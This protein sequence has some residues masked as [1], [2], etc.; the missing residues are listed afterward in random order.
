MRPSLSSLKIESLK[1]L[2]TDRRKMAQHKGVICDECSECPIV[3]IRFISKRTFGFDLCE[4]CVESHHNIDDFH[5]VNSPL[6][7]R[8]ESSLVLEQGSQV[9][10]ATVAQANEQLHSMD[11]DPSHVASFYFFE[12]ACPQEARKNAEEILQFLEQNPI[13]TNLRIA[14]PFNT[15]VEY[16]GIVEVIINGLQELPHI[17][18]IDWS[19]SG[20]WH[21]DD[22]NFPSQQAV[23]SLAEFIAHDTSLQG[24][25]VHIPCTVKDAVTLVEALLRNK[26][27]K[28]FR[29][30]VRYYDNVLSDRKFREIV[31][32][33]LENHPSL[34][35]V[36]LSDRS[37][38]KEAEEPE[39][40]LF[41]NFVLMM[42][43]TSR[44][45]RWKR[46]WCDPSLKDGE[47]VQLI[48][49]MESK[50]DTF[51]RELSLTGFYQVIRPWPE[52]WKHRGV[53]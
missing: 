10:A 23:A 32:R 33:L 34:E 30:S 12:S 26:T 5:T 29:L 4:H 31:Y 27:M 17:K 52:V 2:K 7:F 16:S 20:N 39:V 21:S 3:G 18:H 48:Q 15:S 14:I 11:S 19:I 42:A 41:Q 35:K 37:S 36:F 49:E 13:I 45:S 24:F 46:R 51:P 53:L 44:M 43:E 25:F 6:T 28:C 38:A 1:H 50:L 9:S 40:S 8:E 47:R 22:A